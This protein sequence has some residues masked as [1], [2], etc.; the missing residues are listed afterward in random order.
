MD[1]SDI[2]ETL[3][4][5]Y[6]RLNGYFVSGFIV[7]ATQG[8]VTEVDVLAVRFPCHK[9]SEREVRCCTHLGIPADHIDFIVGEV[10]GG[11]KVN[12]NVSFRENAGSVRS[13]LHR[14]G[15]FAPVEIERVCAVVP[16]LLSP[17]NLRT[18][19]TIPELDVA[20]WDDTKAQRAK[21]R[22][23]LFA[24]GQ[25]RSAK[26]IRPFIFQDDMFRFVWEC[27]RPERQRAFCDVRYNFELWGPQFSKMVQYFKD[28]ARV[29]PGTMT[30]LYAAYG[31]S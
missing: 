15:A 30:D 19:R 25:T 12:F 17:S 22:F 14:C 10:K 16:I 9:E 29:E 3:V 13:V 7:H 27:F 1:K 5:L 31:L 11:R 28:L 18:S 21:L 20:L 24:T 4:H 8:A 6:L 23:V 2:E 26:S